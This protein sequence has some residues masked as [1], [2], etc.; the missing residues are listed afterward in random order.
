MDHLLHQMIHRMMVDNPRTMLIDNPRTMLI[1]NPRIRLTVWISVIH[2]IPYN[3]HAILRGMTLNTPRIV[4]NILQPLLAVEL[5]KK[6]Y[7]HCE[8]ENY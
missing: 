2:I 5:I 7:I 1:D 8:S 4:N 3:L 6:I